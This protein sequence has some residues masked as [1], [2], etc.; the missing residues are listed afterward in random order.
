MNMNMKISEFIRKNEVNKANSKIKKYKEFI[1]V[2]ENDNNWIEITKL[3]T[4]EYEFKLMHPAWNKIKSACNDILD[5]CN[6]CHFRYFSVLIEDRDIAYFKFNE[7]YDKVKAC[8][9]DVDKLFEL[10]TESLNEKIK[11]LEAAY[12]IEKE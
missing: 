2:L 9:G 6:Q 1:E 5:T 3:N 8:N 12:N 10:V 11:E 7:T 4:Y